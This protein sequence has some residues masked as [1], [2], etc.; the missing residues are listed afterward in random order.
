I[1]HIASIDEPRPLAGDKW[2]VY[3]LTLQGDHL[4][5]ELNGETTVDVRDDTLSSGPFALQ[6]GQGTLRFRKVEIM[7][8]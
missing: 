4:K 2:N 5:V 7:P 6:W 1:V 3:I 8:L